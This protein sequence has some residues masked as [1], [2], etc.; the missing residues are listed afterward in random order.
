MTSMGDY[1]NISKCKGIKKT[2]FV[3]IQNIRLLS[4][5]SGEVLRLEGMNN[6]VIVIHDLS[7]VS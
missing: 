1:L 6:Y 3:H 4:S 2:I 7:I 5:I